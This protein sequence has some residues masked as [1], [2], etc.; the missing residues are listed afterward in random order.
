MKISRHIICLTIVL[1][2]LSGS[3]FGQ[4]ND[5]I[6]I[7]GQVVY[8]DNPIEFATVS[9]LSATDQSLLTGTTTDTDGRF[10]LS[11]P[12][13]DIV[14]QISFIGFKTLEI[15]DFSQSKGNIQLG[16]IQ[17]MEDHQQLAEIVV[18]G[19]KSYSE[20]KLDKRVFNVGQDI[21]NTGV[22]ALEVLNNV[23]SVN[24]SIEG[25]IS[26]RGSQGVQILING[27]PSVLTTGDGSALGTITSDMIEKIEVI[28]NPSA[29]YEAEGTS[30]IINIVLKKDEKR[31]LNGSAT[32]NTGVPT[33]HSL[34]LSLNNRTEKFNLFGQLGIG[35]RSMP[36]EISTLNRNLISL[37]E[38]S[39]DGETEKNEKFFNLVLGTDYHIDNSQVLT[40]TGHFAFEDE[41]ANSDLLYHFSPSPTSSLIDMWK[42]EESTTAENPKWQ[43]ELQY[44]KEFNSNEDHFLLFSGLGSYFGKDQFANYNNSTLSGSDRNGEEKIHTDYRSANYTFKLD[45]TQPFNNEFTLETGSQYVINDI[46]NDFSTQDLINDEW[47]TDFNVSNQ[48][49]YQQN[50][51]GIYGTGAYE[52]NKWGLKLGLR[53]ENTDLHTQ[54]INNGNKNHQNYSNLFPSVHTSYKISEKYSVQAGYSS[55]IF[56]P[57][58]WDLN[59]FTNPV[60]DYNIFTGNPNL[61][62]EFTDSYE[63]TAISVQEKISLNFGVYYRYTSDVIERVVRS[64]DNISYTYPDNVGQSKTTGLELNAKYSPLKWASF[65]ADFNYNYFNRTGQFNEDQF[66]FFGDKWMSKLMTKFKLPAEIDLELAG[67]Y[68]SKYQTVQQKVKSNAYMDLGI[69]KKILKGKAILNLS[70]RDVF[71]SRRNESI[72]EQ[73]NFILTN[74]RTTGRFVTFGVSYGFGKGEAMEF[75]GQKRF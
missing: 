2:S 73:S 6:V 70:V 11:S 27:K 10:S 42:R 20:F 33:N 49:E 71:A 65:T 35:K 30:G 63:V 22:S 55:R 67:N 68:G 4:N 14:I 9:L 50:V 37:S 3:L 13:E 8:Y 61:Q 60:D 58:L 40:L 12:S 54:L 62:P 1:I 17:L 34:G 41:D 69:R 25:Q 72:T 74:R 36:R 39:L 18:Q 31:G 64:E 59:P 47:I 28:T 26:L 43:Y 16:T 44:K 53:F 5:N 24:V 48:F 51:L 38:L 32:I 19:D 57:G 29:K 45:Y 15:K 66:D 46:S 21:G 75:S 23:P 7:T 56:R 52:K